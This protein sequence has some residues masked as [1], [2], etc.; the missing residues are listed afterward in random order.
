MLTERNVLYQL[1]QGDFSSSKSEELGVF[2]NISESKI[3]SFTVDAKSSDKLLIR[4]IN[5]WFLND[6]NLSWKY[7]ATALDCVSYHALAK[8]FEEKGINGR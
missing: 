3:Q 8:K 6:R 1:K 7:L 4:I 2:L 5:Y